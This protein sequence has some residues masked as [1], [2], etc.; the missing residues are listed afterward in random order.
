MEFIEKTLCD[1]PF[2]TMDSLASLIRQNHNVSFSG[3]TI[4]R[5]SLEAGFTYKKAVTC[6]DYSHD[7]T[8]VRNFC[9]RFQTAIKNKNL[10]CIDEACFYV[11]DH[12]RKGR[13]RKGSKLAIGTGK[14]LRKTKFTLLLAIGI[15]GIEGYKIQ[16][17]NCKI[18]NFVDFVNDL[19]LPKGSVLLMDNL[20]AHHS[21]DVAYASL[22]KGFELLFT[23]PY[24]PRCNPI[25]KVFGENVALIRIMKHC[26][27]IRKRILEICLMAF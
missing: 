11:G 5:Y 23:P 12:P 1:R 22:M 7:N 20:R 13:A 15:N 9:S 6:V 21:S 10:V 16:E 2:I 19:N 8:L 24:S 26:Y 14:S 27:R 4:S 17:T 18:D 3:R 25:E